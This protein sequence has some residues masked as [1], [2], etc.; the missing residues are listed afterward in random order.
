MSVMRLLRFGVLGALMLALSACSSARPVLY[1]NKHL[2]SV[3]NAKAD[4]DI[5][6]CMALAESYVG[7]GGATEQQGR[8]VAKG[9]AIGGATG[10]ATGAV[11]GA[12]AGDAGTG[13]AVGAATG[14]TAGFLGSIFGVFGDSGP[15][16][17]YQRFVE[18]CLQERGYEPIGWE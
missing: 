17:T 3:G 2:Q 9:T 6:Q 8:N 13:A 5:A 15:S 11:G 16:P 12:I 18:R 7:S 14:A 4:E 10:A 1:P